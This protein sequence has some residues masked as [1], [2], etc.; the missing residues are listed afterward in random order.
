ME[1]SA[2][3]V[4][5]QPWRRKQ[6]AEMLTGAGVSGGRVT[7][8]SPAPSARAAQSAPE[9]STSRRLLGR[10]GAEAQPPAS[11]GPYPEGS[12]VFII[13]SLLSQTVSTSLTY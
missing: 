6:R 2:S 12:L 3:H 1:T 10:W 11:S 7:S 5:R 4:L 8:A 13:F 9:N